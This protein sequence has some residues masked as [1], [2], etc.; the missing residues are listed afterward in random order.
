MKVI[1]GCAFP[2][3]AAVRTLCGGAI[4][5]EQDQVHT[6]STDGSGVTG[7]LAAAGIAGE[8]GDESDSAV[9]GQFI[10][11]FRAGM[12]PSRQVSDVAGAL[13]GKAVIRRLPGAESARWN[14]AG[15][16]GASVFA[17]LA[18]VEVVGDGAESAR[19]FGM[20]ARHPEVLSV[21]PNRVLRVH[22]AGLQPRFPND[23]EFPRLW[24]LW[25][26]GQNGGLVGADIS[27]PE[28]WSVTTGS[29]DVVV[30]VIDT[31]IDF[32]HPDLE[33][34]MWINPGETPGNGIDDDGNGYIDDVHGFDFVWGDSDPMDDMIHGTHVAGI[35]GA[36]GNNTIGVAG[37]AWSVSI[38]ALKAFDEKGE[39]ELWHVI[40]ALHYAGANGARIIN[41]SWGQ[42]EDST[43]LREAIAELRGRGLVVVASAGNK[44]TDKP[45]Y[46]AAFPGVIAVAAV[47]SCD[48]RPFFSN[49][50]PWIDV[51]APGESV[52]STVVNNRYDFL[53]GTSMSAPHVSG[54]AALVWSIRPSFTAEEVEDVL[55][56]AVDPTRAAEYIG[57]GRINAARAVG[58]NPPLPKAVLDLPSVLVGQVDL[59]GTASGE[60]FA[61]YKLE[62]GCGN[63]PANWTTI[64]T[65]SV[66]VEKGVLL[67]GFR[68]DSLAEGA[69]VFRL[70]V[71]DISGQEAVARAVSTVRNVAL[72]RPMDN[73]VLRAG[74]LVTVEGTVFGA[75]R[76]YRLEYGAGARPK[77]W[78]TAGIELANAGRENVVDG[79]LGWWD[80]TLVQTNE[81]YALRLIV[82]AGDEVVAES[83]SQL[84]FLDGQMR[85]GWPKYVPTA[86]NYPTN[87]WREVTV[88]DID[89]DGLKEILRID[90]G[91]NGDKPA[92]LR[93][94]QPDGTLKWSRELAAGDPSHDIPV[95][96]DVD[97][98]GFSEI[99]VDV[100]GFLFA[101]RHD[102]SPMPG[103][104]PV[105]LDVPKLGKVLADLNGDG[106]MELI[107]YAQ[108]PTWTST[109]QTR[110]LVVY[111][112]GGQLVQKWR[113]RD[114]NAGVDVP[115]MFPAVGNL[116]DDPGLEIVAVDGGSD[117][118]MFDI[119]KTDAPVWRARVNGSLVSSPV[120]GDI[121]GDGKV[122]IVA[123]VYDTASK[124]Q[125]GM[126]GGVYA[127][128]Q[129]GMLLPGWPVLIDQSF[130]FAP[131]L[132]DL[133]H[134]RRLEIIISAQ[135]LALHVLRWDG[136]DL[137]GWPVKPPAGLKLASSPVV[138]DINGDGLP[139]V[140][141]ACFGVSLQVAMNGEVSKLGGLC[142]WNADGLPIDLNE[143]AQLSGLMLEHVL[144]K[145]AP[146]VLADLDG[147]GILDVVA[148]TIDDMALPQ[149]L[150]RAYRKNR[151]TISVWALANGRMS[152]NV[153]PWPMLRRDPQHTGYVEPEKPVN[154][155]PQ[156]DRIPDQIVRVGTAFFP[157]ELD[158]Y[159]FDPDNK[160]AELIWETEG[161]VE[162]QVTIGE[163]RTAFVNVPNPDWSGREVI[164]FIVRDPAGSIAETS[165]S[166]EA[167]VDY[168][169][170]VAVADTVTCLE[171]E[172]IE[173]DALANDTHPHG[174]PLA[175]LDFSRPGYGSLERTN[176]NSLRYTPS[177]DYF[178]P[179]SFAYTISD[180]QGGIAMARV[181]IE[182]L[183]VADPPVAEPDRAITNEDEPVEIDVLAND[184]DPDGDHLVIRWF[185]QPEH[186]SVV[187]LEN[188][189][190][191]YEPT[192]DFSGTDKFT[193]RVSDATGNETEG[194]VT[195]M[196]K[197]VND[198]PTAKSFSF[199]INRNTQQTVM[200]QATDNDGDTLTF[201]VVEGPQHGELWSYPDIATYY[202][203]KGYSGIDSFT[204]AASDGVTESAPATVSITVL[205]VNNPPI[206][207]DAAMTTKVG[208]ALPIE[209]EARDADEDPF[210]FTILSLPEHGL[211]TGSGSNYVYSPDPGYIGEDQFFFRAEDAKDAGAPATFTITVTDQNTAPVATNS[212]VEV[213]IDTP[214]EFALEAKDQENDDLSFRLLSL[215]AHGTLSGVPPN[216]TY[217]PERGFVGP[218]KFTFLVSDGELESE[219]A[220]VSIVVILP[221]H[222]PDVKD[223][224]VVAAAE[225]SSP[226]PFAV[227][228]EDGDN[229]KVVILKGPRNGLV[230]G[231]GT[232]YLYTPKPGFLGL[233]WFT[234]RVWDGTVYSDVATVTLSV[235]SHPQF[236]A[237]K[238]EF[239]GLLDGETVQFLIRAT[240][241]SKLELLGSTNLTEWV[242]ITNLTAHDELVPL[243]DTVGEESGMRFYRARSE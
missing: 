190:L 77:E 30:A 220:T 37:V 7:A 154:R 26:T 215:P 141:A 202:P 142:A 216:L 65:G 153:Y 92:V 237:P 8:D 157:I 241:G 229:L 191:R 107:G 182:V 133:D 105:P 121:N 85:S 221:N 113:L 152:P 146:P 219:P 38:M 60:C 120:I 132:A 185:G 164:R 225:K 172:S 192:P 35:I 20:L 45:S 236:M 79:V 49:H 51:A 95:A 232:N 233:D 70:T 165:A 54:V 55:R 127:W 158:R 17:R 34:N 240:P 238:F 143:H 27:A 64:G 76:T 3:L 69:Y 29:R 200:Y 119:G 208:R 126:A 204:Y 14:L 57:L 188:T 212:W 11:L 110:Q 4:G 129:Q 224:T 206:A 148:T 16:G 201:R 52:L 78:L 169:P 18:L 67:S 102:G 137:P 111:N 156:L 227:K 135:G 74:D 5:G 159:V 97:G 222:A 235:Q 21:E 72:S 210:V 214:K 193:Y 139:D 168:D 136:F 66:P 179:D 231:I 150:S 24:N 173:I 48:E 96:G 131:A 100:G 42:K 82:M 62:W 47:N 88:V 118:V 242:S 125:P 134:D 39:G 44:Q 149:T 90:A 138:G 147:D 211:L 43:A 33:R 108:M 176:Q 46:P 93:V 166:F 86:G 25:N 170:P 9:P 183:P 199:T 198:P 31:G 116:D 63:Y 99:F 187:M 140:I 167:R 174:L 243:T 184:H 160:P 124:G 115:R 144:M 19:V 171:D 2:V 117:L 226:V 151:Y 177:K 81:F 112:T 83:K 114:F 209:L 103:N 194:E 58:V 161:N 186:G 73:D 50:G 61:G 59:K 128:D 234:Y 175:L 10:V 94:Y 207:L 40:E 101:L 41:A 23:F 122:E 197:P 91:D 22:G 13:P 89:N 68:T 15:G 56:N 218:D 180:G 228:D 239:V 155:P 6:F 32:F 163:N 71:W 80:T 75:G 203:K 205:D 12:G 230:S 181:A 195:V 87:D 28:A 53:S 162:L 223:Q 84:I 36:V 123:G 98:D 104:W 145:S 109:Q 1:L 106:R 213:L 178:G 217:S 130:P 196:V 189:A